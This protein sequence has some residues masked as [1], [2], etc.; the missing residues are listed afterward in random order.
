MAGGVPTVA[1]KSRGTIKKGKHQSP[2]GFDGFLSK[3]VA[4]TLGSR[5]NRKVR[6]KGSRKAMFKR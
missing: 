5:N 2:G 6:R 4:R 3:S 1:R